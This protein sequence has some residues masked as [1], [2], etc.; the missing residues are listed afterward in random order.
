MSNSILAEFIALQKGLTIL[1]LFYA[2]KRSRH[3]YMYKLKILFLSCLFLTVSCQHRKLDFRV[4]AGLEEKLRIP[5]TEQAV[6]IDG[7][8]LDPIWEKAPGIRLDTLYKGP[9]NGESDIKSRGLMKL[10]WDEHYL[11]IAY[12]INDENLVILPSET[13]NGPPGAERNGLVVWHEK[14]KV[15]YLQLFIAPSGTNF[16]WE[17]HHN[18]ANQFNDVYVIVLDESWDNY[19]S[20]LAGDSHI[21]FLEEVYL[22]DQ[23]RFNFKKGSED[24]YSFQSKSKLKGQSTVRPDGKPDNKDKGY[25]AE[26][27]IP[28]GALGLNKE[29][30]KKGLWSLQGSGIRLLAAIKDGDLKYAR[31]STK[32]AADKS[33]HKQAHNFPYFIFVKD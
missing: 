21:M 5:Y 32:L 26:L 7:L 27:R 31:A 12:E 33:F 14:I 1:N 23:K 25:W 13:K 18:A 4:T 6:I 17:L 11:Y 24:V 15:D 9:N 19:Q 2:K 3:L 16:F 29:R 20:S 28:L 30:Q 8:L 22:K 10:A